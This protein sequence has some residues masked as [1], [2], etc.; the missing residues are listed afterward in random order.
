VSFLSDHYQRTYTKYRKKTNLTARILV[1]YASWKEPTAGITQA[2]GR[3]LE[4]RYTVNVSEMKS[5]TSIAGYKAVVIGGPVYTGKITGD[6]T[7]FVSTNKDELSGVLVEG[8]G[9]CTGIF[10]RLAM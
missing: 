10:Q 6:V 2:I 1:A 8:Y 9:H 5:V 3:E 7:V 4:D